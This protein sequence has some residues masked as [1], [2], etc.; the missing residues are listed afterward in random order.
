MTTDLI[1]RL[2]GQWWTFLLRGI[3]ALGL[4]VL[5]FAAPA[6]MA[7]GLVYFV[8]AFFIVSGALA[9]LAGV[10]FTGVG[11]WWALILTGLVQ[12]ALGIIMLAEPGAGPLALAFFVAIWAFSTGVMEISSAIALRSYIDNEFWWI[13][14]GV[15]TLV[16]G[17]YVVARPDL[18]ILALVYSIGIYAA[19]AAGTLIGLA[20]RIKNAGHEIEKYRTAAKQAAQV[21]HR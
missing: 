14:L 17:V 2:T 13:L 7:S 10:S 5:A 1:E 8:A 4:A 20:F 18:G 12:A 15:M 3:V 6:A 11:S 19:L 9:L 16:F 21:A